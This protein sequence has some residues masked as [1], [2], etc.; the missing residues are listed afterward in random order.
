M[1]IDVLGKT[2]HSI[3]VEYWDPNE[4]HGHL[5]LLSDDQDPVTMRELLVDI[6]AW[7]DELAQLF[8]QCNED[9]HGGRGHNH[10]TDVVKRAYEAA[11]FQLL[12][13]DYQMEW[14]EIERKQRIFKKWGKRQPPAMVL[15]PA[16]D[17]PKRWEALIPDKEGNPML[18]GVRKGIMDDILD[19]PRDV[20]K[21]NKHGL[22][23]TLD[24]RKN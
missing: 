16:I 4:Q 15:Q 10:D 20:A 14:E 24:K 9:R 2:A 23:W 3:W 12:T 18:Y 1:A 17:D 19:D 13:T 8:L 5:L 11:V 22:G 21:P 7:G 6:E